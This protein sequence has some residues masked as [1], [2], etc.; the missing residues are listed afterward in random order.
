MNNERELYNVYV[1]TNEAGY[2]IAVNSSAF[3]DDTTD[4]VKIDEGEGDKHH[5]AQGNYFPKNIITGAGVY[6]YKLVNGAPVECTAEEIARQEAANQP[7]DP[8]NT[9]GTAEEQLAELS[10]AIERGLT[11]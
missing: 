2:I 3:L 8:P 6:Q 4:W 11:T 10:A 1:K 9:G 7:Q 5:H